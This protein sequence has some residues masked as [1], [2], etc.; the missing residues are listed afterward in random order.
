M[1]QRNYESKNEKAER[2]LENHRV[3]LTGFRKAMAIGDHQ[4]YLVEKKG[5]QWSCDCKWGCY[6]GAWTDCSHVIAVKRAR[7]DPLSQ[8]PVARLADLLM[9]AKVG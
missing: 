5:S 3:I 8:A 1:C 7:K 9:E 6:R 2:L 4:T